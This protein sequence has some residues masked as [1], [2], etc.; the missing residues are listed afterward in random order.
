[1]CSVQ[2]AV[3]SV[4]CAVQCRSGRHQRRKKIYRDCTKHQT[5]RDNQS[6]ISRSAGAANWKPPPLHVKLDMST[7]F[8]FELQLSETR[9]ETTDTLCRT[10][11]VMYI[12]Y[13]PGSS[14]QTQP[15]FLGE[16]CSNTWM[17][18]F[19]SDGLTRILGDSTSQ[20]EM[21]QKEITRHFQNGMHGRLDRLTDIQGAICQFVKSF[22]MVSD[23]R[24]PK[25]RLEDGYV[26]STQLVFTY[27]NPPL[28]A[29]AQGSFSF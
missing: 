28:P 21:L 12:Y 13:R 14:L 7:S 3:C 10:F 18:E 5:H 23:L 4:Q 26:T 11:D 22:N 16:L 24:S 2:C 27:R 15:T 9:S 29:V 8:P 17:F 20:K 6:R 1:M 19:G 25:F